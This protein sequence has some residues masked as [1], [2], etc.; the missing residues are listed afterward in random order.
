M[1]FSQF[2]RTS[3]SYKKYDGETIPMHFAKKKTKKI[4]SMSGSIV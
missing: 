3:Q 1:K 2:N 4:E